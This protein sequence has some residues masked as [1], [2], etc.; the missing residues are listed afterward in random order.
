MLLPRLVLCTPLSLLGVGWG[1]GIGI[2]LIVMND[3]SQCL[4]LP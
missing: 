3:L 4:Q 2:E 1:L